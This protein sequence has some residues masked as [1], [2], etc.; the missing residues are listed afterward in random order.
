MPPE[1]HGVEP[2]RGQSSATAEGERRPFY[3]ERPIDARL[4][5]SGATGNIPQRL[6]V[7]PRAAPAATGDRVRT[8]VSGVWS[9]GPQPAHR[10][11]IDGM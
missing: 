4:K 9:D 8:G 7:F 10:I 6:W 1:V 5:S 3:R 11:G 2:P